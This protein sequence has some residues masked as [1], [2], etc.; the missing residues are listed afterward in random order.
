MFGVSAAQGRELHETYDIAPNGTVSVSNTSGN[1]RVTSWNENRVKVDAVKHGRNED[2]INQVQI[3]VNATAGRLEIRTIYPRSRMNVSVDYDLKVPATVALN[4]ITSTSGEVT[5][6]GPIANAT[7]RSTS[8]NVMAR[9]ITESASL[10]STSGNVTAEKVGGELRATSTSG[11]VTVTDVGSRLYAQSTSGNVRAVQ[12]RDDATAS[13]TSGNVTLEKVGGRATGRSMS[14]RVAIT[15]AGGDAQADSLSDTVT[16]INVRGRATASSVSGDA[17]VRQAGEGAR[18]TSVSGSVELTDVKGRVE[19]GTTSGSIQMANV[20][21][22]D[23]SAKCTSG[24]VRFTGKLHEDGLYTFE[25]FSS[26]VILFVPADSQFRL[27]ARSRSGSINTEFPLQV[28]GLGGERGLVSGTVG[29]GGAE[30][31]A[32]TFSGNVYI[33]KIQ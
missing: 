15:D 30:I 27:T 22:R 8:G 4:A 23:V 16:I 7:A 13:A 28:S 32:S 31:R 9:A 10:T 3:Q 21:S 6:T 26:N 17:I 12:I 24:D 33:K 2:E 14:G 25:S 19:A 20:D 29:K 11:N 18:A 1:I 5:L